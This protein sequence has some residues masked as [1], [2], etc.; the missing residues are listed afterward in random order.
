MHLF[1]PFKK[2]KKKTATYQPPF[3]GGDL[4]A[5]KLTEEGS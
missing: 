2:K 1:M 5:A 4:G 3:L